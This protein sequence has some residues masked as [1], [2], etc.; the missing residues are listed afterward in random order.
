MPQ[1]LTF[2]STYI[3]TSAGLFS[4]LVSHMVATRIR[5]PQIIGKLRKTSTAPATTTAIGATAST[6]RETI[7]PSLGASGAI[8]SAVVIT[9]LAYPQSEVALIFPP[10]PPIPIQWGVSALVALDVVG[11][12]RGWK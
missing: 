7:L 3:L 6:A 10:T 5:F 1:D 12:L 8:Y 11:V 2:L 4:G 9:A